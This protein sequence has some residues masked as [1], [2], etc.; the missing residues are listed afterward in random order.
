MEINKKNI[1]GGLTALI[2]I[3]F[4]LIFFSVMYLIAGNS[5]RQ[6]DNLTVYTPKDSLHEGFVGKTNALLEFL[7]DS[8]KNEYVGK[9]SAV[10]LNSLNK[11]YKA[12][13]FA[14][15]NEGTSEITRGE[16]LRLVGIMPDSIKDERLRRFYYNSNIPLLLKKQQSNLADNI[17]QIQ[18][19][20]DKHAKTIIK[21]DGLKRTPFCVAS[22][23]IDASMFSVSLSNKMWEGK[24]YCNYNHLF[25]DSDFVY[26]TCNN[27]V[28][29]VLK[30]SNL[31]DENGEKRDFSNIYLDS[32][33]DE[34]YYEQE[35]QP[36][37]YYKYY[38]GIMEHNKKWVTIHIDNKCS[39]DISIKKTP[40][41]KV[42]CKIKSRDYNLYSEDAT[43][44]NQNSREEELKN[45][46]F[47]ITDGKRIL[48]YQ[49]STERLEGEIILWKQNPARCLSQII[50]TSS[51]KKRYIVTNNQTDLLTQQISTGL[52]GSINNNIYT[53]DSISISLDPILSKEFQT[54][55]QNYLKTLRKRMHEDPKDATEYDMSVTIMDMAT[56]EIIASPYWSTRL[57]NEPQKLRCLHKNTS[58]VRRYIGSTFKPL[59]SLAA[60]LE[61]P[62]LLNL[63]TR[64]VHLYQRNG[65][66]INFLG[67]KVKKGW[68]ASIWNGC[69]MT[70]FLAKS[71]DV[72]PVVLAAIC[73]NDGPFNGSFQ[74]NNKGWF[75]QENGFL[76]FRKYDE[77]T[78]WNNNI[79]FIQNL[80]YLYHLDY[81]GNE[82]KSD[83]WRVIQK[84]MVNPMKPFELESLTPHPVSL[85][86]D[87]FLQGE[88]ISIGLVPWVLGQGN[89]EWNCVKLAEAWSR[90]MTLKDIKA[91]FIQLEKEDNPLP[92]N[93]KRED[94]KNFL[95]K[96]KD[97]AFKPVCTYREMTSKVYSLHKNLVLYAK[98]GTPDEYE[99]REEMLLDAGNRWFDSGLFV[100]SLVDKNKFAVYTNHPKTETPHG[101]TCVVRITKTTNRKPNEKEK[102]ENINSSNALKFF[103][104]NE[105]L[106]KMYELT[107]NY[108]H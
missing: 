91:S 13:K 25:N 90:M 52:I 75:K 45:K 93:F 86:M 16:E 50:V 77:K 33:S 58:L 101:I 7:T 14:L 88:Y 23:K 46:A 59:L 10:D 26:L 64:K 17:F 3:V 54:E 19:Q 79:D 35:S 81:N 34:A 31:F 39:V 2:V 51:G 15:V 28:L 44:K 97:A 1:K 41:G 40:K 74:Y 5:L 42:L 32:H 83:F 49:K 22:I 99:R 68:G 57:D 78:G 103:T 96:L 72:F 9:N 21:K 37:D 98:T 102:D 12:L 80:S 60:V 56:G 71:D 69:N 87:L 70:Q 100:F 63:D 43:I 30:G 95:D 61:Y 104:E 11:K 6:N 106:Q 62:N 38:K 107:K 53:K 108:I 105:R 48:I 55:I 89:N 82:A 29:P 76:K 73:F 47:E 8:T 66:N 4:W 18:L 65:T 84:N 20:V 27:F 92:L 36:M 85:N 94:W 24:I 67:Y